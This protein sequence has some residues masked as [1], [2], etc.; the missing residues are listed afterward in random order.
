MKFITIYDQSISDSADTLFIVLPVI[1][2]FIGIALF[3]FSKKISIN[4]SLLLK[5]FAI[6]YVIV[7][8][9]LLLFNVH[10]MPYGG[11]DYE[12]FTINNIKFRYS[13]FNNWGGF[14][15]TSSHGGPIN[16]NGQYIR[17]SYFKD[18]NENIICKLEILEN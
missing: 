13:D 3:F 4:N 18:D 15:K 12:S 10:P 17:I 1:M 7:V 2:L 16:K 5:K 8:S 6:I 11:H 9:L 14:N